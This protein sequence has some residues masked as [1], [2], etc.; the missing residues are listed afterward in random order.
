MHRQSRCLEAADGDDLCTLKSVFHLPTDARPMTLHP[1][2]KMKELR[3]RPTADGHSSLK[4]SPFEFQIAC[5]HFLDLW[6][7]P[8]LPRHTAHSDPNC[9]QIAVHSST[10]AIEHCAFSLQCGCK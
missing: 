8:S 1:E 2:A 7:P 5:H 9:R 10:L 3:N 6:Y 4:L